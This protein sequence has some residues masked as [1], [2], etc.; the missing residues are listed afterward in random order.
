MSASAVDHARARRRPAAGS[1]ARASRSGRLV[2]ARPAPASPAPAGWEVRQVAAWPPPPPR[3]RRRPARRPRRWRPARR[4]GRP[5]R[6]RTRRGRRPRSSPGRP[7]R[8]SSPAV[9]MTTSQQPRMAAL[10]AKQRPEVMPTSGTSPLSR[11]KRWNAMVSRPDTPG[12]VGVAGPAAAALGEE[13]DRQPQPLDDVEQ[14][15]LLAVVLVALG[16]GQHRV[17]V[18]Q[19]RGRAGRRRVPM[20]ATRP[21]AGRA[22]DEVL[23]PS[24][25]G[26][27]RR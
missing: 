23:E 11:P 20:P 9:A 17:V 7:C 18:R 14:A 2:G 3:P 6:A 19:H 27:G 4:S 24:A 12:R 10:P 15:V 16:A 1:R 5:P 13:H 26:A 25:G 22:G 21:S 8:C